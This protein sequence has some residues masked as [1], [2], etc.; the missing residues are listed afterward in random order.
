[1]GS[2]SWPS[3]MERGRA[4]P[5]ARVQRLRGRREAWDTRVFD[6]AV[7]MSSAHD[8]DHEGKLVSC[9]GLRAEDDAA[10]WSPCTVSNVHT[11]KAACFQRRPWWGRELSRFICR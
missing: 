2:A 3:R 10:L 5:R 1:M 9:T 4:R 11:V 7:W 6:I 8:S